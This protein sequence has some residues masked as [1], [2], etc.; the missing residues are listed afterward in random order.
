MCAPR[1]HAR[2]LKMLEKDGSAI[3]VGTLFLLTGWERFE[4][5]LLNF[6][7]MP[8]HWHLVVWPREDG[9]LST[10]LQW[11]TVTH[12]RRWHAHYHTGGTGPIY[13]G[14]FKSFPIQQGEHFLTVCRCVERN[15]LRANLVAEARSEPTHCIIPW[16]KGLTMPAIVS[17]AVPKAP[18]KHVA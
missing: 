6:L 14:R 5:C 15:A 8:N 4:M 7:I 16:A 18:E 10:Y 9:A 11:V 12:V 2:P 17:P 1:L 3:R 13:Q